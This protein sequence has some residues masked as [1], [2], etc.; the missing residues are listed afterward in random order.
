MNN[1]MIA[2]SKIATTNIFST[3]LANKFNE[4]FIEN[5]ISMSIKRFVY[6]E[7][8]RNKY[9]ENEDSHSATVK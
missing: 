3:D 6:N 4:Y 8:V 9:E 7:K 1:T 5:C 2:S